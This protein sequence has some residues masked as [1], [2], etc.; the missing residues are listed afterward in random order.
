[1]VALQ[2]PHSGQGKRIALGVYPDVGLKDAREKL[3]EIRKQLASN[4]DP[5]EQRKAKKAVLIEKAENTFEAIAREWFAL[6][7]PKWVS[8]HGDKIIRRLEINVFP[9]L[10]TRPIR[11]V[12]APELLSVI[13]RNCRAFTLALLAART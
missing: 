13:R 6:N 8:N 9:W 2:V 4:I 1:M 12:T 7:S 10:G 3:D 5:S 11:E